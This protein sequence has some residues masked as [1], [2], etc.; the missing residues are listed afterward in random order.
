MLRKIACVYGIIFIVI[1][2]LGFFPSVTPNY[3]LLGIFHVNTVHNVI[4][5]ATGVIALWTGLISSN[6]AKGFFQIFGIVYLLVAISG[7]IYG[8]RD[9]LGLVANNAADNWLHLSISAITLYLGFSKT[10][11][12]HN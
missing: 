1:G 4:H 2:I 11:I 6:A 9:I 7:F 12:L 3:H 8:N 5:I 10:P